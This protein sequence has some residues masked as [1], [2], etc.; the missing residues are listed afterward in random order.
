MNIDIE[1][2][3][4]PPRVV[5]VKCKECRYYRDEFWNC[6]GEK[7]T[8]WA[9]EEN[10][11][12]TI[13]RNTSQSGSDVVVDNGDGVFYKIPSSYLYDKL[14]DL[15][16]E[17]KEPGSITEWHVDRAQQII[18]HLGE[19]CSYS[20]ESTLK[21]ARAKAV[22]DSII[23]RYYIEHPLWKEIMPR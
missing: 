3:K 19:L 18:K 13:E 10:Q 5:D 20:Q 15:E 22:S 11:V 8:C 4:E 21:Y 16:E 6:L 7:K 17:T 12:T 1:R 2:L 9:F 14:W 23:C